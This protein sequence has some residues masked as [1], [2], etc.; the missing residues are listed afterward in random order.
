MKE[1]EDNLSPRTFE[2]LQYAL[3]EGYHKFEC[4]DTESGA[5][6]VLWAVKF[7]IDWGY[8][9]LAVSNIQDVQSR[10]P[11]PEIAAQ[12]SWY[13]GVIADLQSSRAGS[14]DYFNKAL[15]LYRST[16]DYQA[17]AVCLARLGRLS[18]SINDFAK[19]NEFFNNCIE[20]CKQR[21]VTGGWASS[22][23][24]MGWNVNESTGEFE[25]SIALYEQSI[26]KA[27]ESKDLKTLCAAK[28]Q[29]GF[30][31]WTRKN[32]KEETLKLYDDARRICEEHRLVK[33]M[34]AIH[35][36]LSYLYAENM[37]FEKAK[38]NCSKC[39]EIYTGLGNNYGLTN[40]YANLGKIYESQNDPES[41]IHWLNKSHEL[42]VI[43]NNPGG[44]AWA[45][46]Q[47]GRIFHKQGKT[48]D[49]LDALS[50]AIKLSEEKQLKETLL[51]AQKKLAE[52]K[53]SK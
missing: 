11:K 38:E 10:S 16:G 43:V 8:I 32:R 24:G 36:D 28:R 42:S 48:T 29:M 21:G 51:F 25:R 1:S 30:L 15:E 19:A 2:D 9:E 5:D 23:L 52:I 18:N 39:V 31:L 17:E 14:I 47:L 33:E 12:C 49:A 26:L 41:A 37:E 6:I 7:L 40:A 34:G 44:Q 4:G 3:E 13:N 20:L 46:Y 53:R 22:L 27:G 45:L 35:A 50:K